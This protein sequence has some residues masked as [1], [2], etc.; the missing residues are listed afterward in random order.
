MNNLT[1]RELY[2]L[3][4]CMDWQTCSH[5]GCKARR[6]IERLTRERDDAARL[7]G[8][9]EALDALR[10]RKTLES[11][12]AAWEKRA[13]EAE[14]DWRRLRV[15]LDNLVG[16]VG[17]LSDPE[18]QLSCIPA[19]PEAEELWQAWKDGEAALSG[20]PT[21][22][23][24]TYRDPETLTAALERAKPWLVWS[25]DSPGPQWQLNEVKAEVEKALSGP[26]RPRIRPGVMERLQK[27]ER[28]S[29]KATAYPHNPPD[30]CLDC[31]RV[32]RSAH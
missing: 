10:D 2:L 32:E 3:T 30:G 28:P 8:T 20:E 29:E 16:A 19:G 4:E 14:A 22:A 11:E 13:M 15:A 24:E 6:E 17:A 9:K 31:L 5:A 18:D 27:L 12:R 7:Y 26:S 1:N 23:P 21:S 25:P